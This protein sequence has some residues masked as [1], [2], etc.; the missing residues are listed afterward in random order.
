MIYGAIWRDTKAFECKRNG[1]YIY[2]SVPLISVAG[3][4][5]GD[6]PVEYLVRF[7]TICDTSVSFS[8]GVGGAELLLKSSVIPHIQTLTLKFR[9]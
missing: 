2:V 6:N 1:F 8:C 4:Y 9:C 7:G 5:G 3:K